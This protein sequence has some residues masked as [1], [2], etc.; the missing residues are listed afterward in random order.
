[1][2][3]IPISA[4]PNQSFTLTL[5]E[6]Q[7]Q[8]AL[9]TTNGVTSVSLVLNGEEVITNMRAVAN[10][11]IIPCEYQ[12]AGN[13]IFITQNF[14]LPEY[15]QFGITQTLVY[16]SASELEAIRTPTPSQITND[17]FNPIAAFPLRYKPQGYVL[18]P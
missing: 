15:T 9:K 6:N 3:T 1:M 11:K 8:V 10:K 14:Q 17:F 16:A 2:Q 5:D 13:F 12:E 18:A 7:W 4:I